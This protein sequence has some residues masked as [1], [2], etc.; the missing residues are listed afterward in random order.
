MTKSGL[1]S[2]DRAIGLWRPLTGVCFCL[3][4][5]ADNVAKSSN[6]SPPINIL[7][8]SDSDTERV[9]VGSQLT[10]R[11]A[12]GCISL[13][14]STNVSACFGLVSTMLRRNCEMFGLLNARSSLRGFLS[15]RSCDVRF[16]FD[17]HVP[18]GSVTFPC[19]ACSDV[20]VDVFVVVVVSWCRV[21]VGGRSWSSA[22]HVVAR[23][24]PPE[25]SVHVVR[26]KDSGSN[27]FPAFMESGFGFDPAP[28]R[29]LPWCCRERSKLLVAS[30]MGPR[31]LV[32]VELAAST[33]QLIDVEGSRWWSVVG[34]RCLS[35]SWCP[36]ELQL[37]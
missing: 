17:D 37:L 1:S 21:F 24:L 7:Y 19:S 32:F 16:A 29:Q 8:C 18:C 13:P 20:E 15:V 14:A 22:T 28:V 30:D 2:R 6:Q 12:N 34:R 36:T 23:P 5:A 35:S 10:L 3:S 11:S 25:V 26:L 31:T 4:V 27:L 9:F 33:Y